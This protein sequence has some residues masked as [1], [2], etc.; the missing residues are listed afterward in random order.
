M[1]IQ[2]RTSQPKIC[3]ILQKISKFANFA[4][5]LPILPICQFCNQRATG[6]VFLRDK[7]MGGAQ[8]PRIAMWGVDFAKT[9]DLLRVA[10]RDGSFFV[11]VNGAERLRTKVNAPAEE[12]YMAIELFGTQ[13]IA[14]P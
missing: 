1:G 5:I 13:A 14:L 6:R 4:T 2:P 8:A 11:H 9:G 12:L 3:K 7:P 10:V